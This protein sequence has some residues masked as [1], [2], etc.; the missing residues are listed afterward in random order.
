MDIKDIKQAASVIKAQAQ[1]V[2]QETAEQIKMIADE[3]LEKAKLATQETIAIATEILNET[4]EKAVANATLAKEKLSEGVSRAV[5]L[6]KAGRTQVELFLKDPDKVENTLLAI[7]GT[8]K[9]VPGI[10]DDLADAQVVISMI[11]SYI[12]KEYTS[13]PYDAI[14]YAFSAIISLI[15]GTRDVLS[16]LPESVQEKLSANADIQKLKDGTV[17]FSDVIAVIRDDIDNY[18]KWRAEKPSSNE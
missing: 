11:R 16:I 7:E 17:K 8:L 13:A 2:Y 3:K 18:R 9:Q 1:V 14:V 10:G 5:E 4:K 15:P 6:L 12:T